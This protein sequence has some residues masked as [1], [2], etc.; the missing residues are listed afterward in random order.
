MKRFLWIAT[1]CSVTVGCGETA[2]TFVE[3]P[4]RGRGTAPQTFVKDGWEVTLSQ[5]TLGFGPIYFCATESALSSRCEVAILEYTEGAT[6][7][8]LDPT[9]QS[10]GSLLGTTGTVHTAFFDYGVVWL[11]TEPLPEALP[12]VPGG[13]AV[14][15][16]ESPSYVP[17]GH[18]GRFWGSAACI[19]DAAICCPG[20]TTCPSSYTFEASVDVLVVNAGTPA[21]NGARTVQEISTGPLALTITF[22]PNLWWQ[23]V[24]F[25]RLAALDDGSQEVVLGPDDPDYSA[26]V[27][28]MTTNVLPTFT[29][30]VPATDE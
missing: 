1:I 8:G 17:E 15:R 30:S 5:A 6:L 14:V 7:N 10:I 3:V 28:A 12:G 26:L 19:D 24:D 27:I 9:E 4:F 13:P 11:L 25:G 29:W 21:V 20:A 23:A 18:S 16:F 22:D 2:G